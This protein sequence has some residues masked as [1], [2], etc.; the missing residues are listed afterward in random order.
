MNLKKIVCSTV[1][2]TMIFSVPFAADAAADSANERLAQIEID[3]YGGEQSGAILDR[4]NRLEDAFSGNNMR[5][6]MNA[7][8]E[9]IYDIIYDNGAEPGI[10][11]KINALEW[12]VNHE[13][14]S[15]GIDKRLTNLENSIFGATY[16]ENNF[17]D[18]I[19][20]LS[21]E[22]FGTEDLPMIQIQLPANT[23][24]KVA[25][26]E[27]VGTRTLQVGDTISVKVTEDV[28]VGGDL[29]FAKGLQGEGIVTEVRRGKNIGRNGKIVID[30]QSVRGIDGQSVATFTGDEA[31]EEMKKESMSAGLS[32]VG[33]NPPPSKS[34]SFGEITNA[35]SRGKNFDIP[36]GTVF[37]VQTKDTAN[38]Y[39]V[40]GGS[41]ILEI[42]PNEEVE[43]EDYPEN[44]EE[45][46]N[47]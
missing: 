40:Q 15:D 6:N 13:V 23:F 41:N 11:A 22:S 21:K 1:A 20:A 10:L 17:S 14:S 42:V 47:V 2:A 36:A 34:G 24:I 9:A 7:R 31:K 26:T 4:L 27:E 3:T 12:N 16:E 25:L 38:V 44:E 18:R 28:V 39:A 5:G 32:L 46:G 30:V 19:R 8:I 37:I 29:V 45:L 43:T 35:L 33:G